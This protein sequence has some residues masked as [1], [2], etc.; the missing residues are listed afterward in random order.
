[1][2]REAA[3]ETA[4]KIRVVAPFAADPALAATAWIR[5]GVTELH[6]EGWSDEIADRCLDAWRDLPRNV[7]GEH[8]TLAIRLLFLQTSR[9]AYANA[10]T[11]AR[12]LLPQALASGNVADCVFCYYS[13]GVA[14][15]HLGRWED[16]RS[17]AHEGAAVSDRTG[18]GRHAAIMRL[19]QAWIAFE[20]Q[21]FEDALR[22]S[23]A[24]R[25]QAEAQSWTNAQQ[26][27]LLF[28][29][30]SAPRARPHRRGRRRS[31]APPR[32]V[33]ARTRADGLV[34]GSAAAHPP[35]R[36]VTAAGRRRARDYRSRRGA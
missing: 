4:R 27:S 21:R 14:A 31:R 32:L 18:S 17:A 34:L 26:M 1:M 29:G 30:A 13:L 33:R 7:T 23:L 10:W 9:S 11:A 6:F 16:A 24:E 20:E 35:R 22:L 3:L 25:E 28:A 5:A 8:R 2:S 15:L 19:L 36:V 12:K